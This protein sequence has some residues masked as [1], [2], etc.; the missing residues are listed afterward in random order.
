M[1]V[2]AHYYHVYVK[3]MHWCKTE[4]LVSTTKIICVYICSCLVKYMSVRQLIICVY[5]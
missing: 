1:L 2:L 4:L 3:H 5:I